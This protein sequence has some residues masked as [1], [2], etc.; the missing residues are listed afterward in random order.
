[1]TK[2]EIVWSFLAELELCTDISGLEALFSRTLEKLGIPLFAYNIYRMN[3]NIALN[4]T[5]RSA[6]N[7]VIS[8]F[9]Q[10][11]RTH[12]FREKY[13]QIDP[14][15]RW[16]DTGKGAVRWDALL[17][18][19]EIQGKQR[20]LLQEARDAGLVDGVT[21][22]VVTELGESVAVSIVAGPGRDGTERIMA[23]LPIVQVLAQGY[24]RRAKGIL[25][26]QSLKIGSARRK[27][28]LSPREI[29]VLTWTAKGK[30]A[31]EIAEILGISQK[32][33]DFYV[34]MAKTKLQAANRTHAVVK[35]IMLGLVRLD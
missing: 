12:Y 3:G 8:N 35:A 6:Q 11:W 31:W 28:L 19:D 16:L 21:L 4:L 27:F 17:A 24:H 34:D 20:R 1:M 22:P 10:P 33:V 29:D 26:G 25:L 5:A 23:A 9:P 7:F 30:T 18:S 14:V 13:E 15:F 2:M 32:S